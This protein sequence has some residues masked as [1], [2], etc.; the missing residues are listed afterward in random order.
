MF[1]HI[2][3]FNINFTCGCYYYYYMSGQ[4]V[5]IQYFFQNRNLKKNSFKIKG[6]LKHFESFTVEL[7]L[8][9]HQGCISCINYPSNK[10]CFIRQV[11]NKPERAI[12]LVNVWLLFCVLFSELFTGF[13]SSLFKV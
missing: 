11:L 10:L 3:H 6:R 4:N 8:S 5:L 9:N 2:H 7:I 13:L 12:H 1:Y